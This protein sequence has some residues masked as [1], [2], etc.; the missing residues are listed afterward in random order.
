MRSS[1][2][3]ST[4]GSL[5][6]PPRAPTWPPGFGVARR[7]GC[8]RR[9][10]RRRTGPSW[11]PEQRT[12][13]ARR[14]RPAASWRADRRSRHL[15]GRRLVSRAGTPGRARA[16]A[17]PRLAGEQRRDRQADPQLRAAHLRLLLARRLRQP[18]LVQGQERRRQLQQVDELPQ[19][20][21]GAGDREDEGA[22][23]Q[24]EVLDLP[25]GIGDRARAQ[26]GLASQRLDLGGDA[27][28]ALAAG[29]EAVVELRRSAASVV[30]AWTSRRSRSTRCACSGWSCSCGLAGGRPPATAPGRRSRS[31]RSRTPR[32][33][34][35]R[36]A[37]RAARPR[38]RW[39][40]ISDWSRI[41]VR[42]APGCSGRQPPGPEP[43]SE[44]ESESESPPRS[45]ALP[46]RPSA[47]R[48]PGR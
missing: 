19:L 36:T 45:A 44:S 47:A 20:G 30:R 14:A 16:F 35:G 29:R 3:V 38:A 22:L 32:R 9:Q 18:D 21:V 10:H 40:Q 5:V 41:M 39:R 13:R 17:L 46:A 43:G 11:L 42:Q 7:R 4:A 2:T 27:G 33:S 8:R 1:T 25:L 48:S 6:D 26:P 12:A 15:P 28:Q 24:P 37:A 31:G 23:D 34:P